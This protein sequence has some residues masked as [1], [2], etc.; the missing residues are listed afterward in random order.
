MSTRSV[1]HQI[2]CMKAI[3]SGRITA[4]WCFLP[5]D[6]ERTQSS[7]SHEDTVAFSSQSIFKERQGYSLL[8][9]CGWVTF[10][11]RNRPGGY[12]LVDHN[13][14]ALAERAFQQAR[15][16]LE[17]EHNQIDLSALSSQM[18]CGLLLHPYL[19]RSSVLVYCD[20]YYP[21]VQSFN[22]LAGQ[23]MTDDTS[24]R[25]VKLSDQILRPLSRRYQ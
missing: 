25:V 11:G 10:Y 14:T 9:H 16:H 3:I 15:E 17:A 6:G 13:L 1:R 5:V 18:L 4:S 22:R 20:L 8:R 23:L 7:S 24:F 21:R 12:G 19:V 2:R